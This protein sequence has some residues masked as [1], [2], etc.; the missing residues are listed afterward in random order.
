[1]S[2]EHSELFLSEMEKARESAPLVTLEVELFASRETRE[3]RKRLKG[4]CIITNIKNIDRSC[5][6]IYLVAYDFL[7]L[8]PCLHLFVEYS[9]RLCTII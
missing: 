8:L 4:L 2:T 9:V 6:F 1:M 5:I 3:L 7:S